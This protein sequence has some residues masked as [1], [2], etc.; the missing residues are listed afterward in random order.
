MHVFALQGIYI[1]GLPL[2]CLWRSTFH[3]VRKR[4]PFMSKVAIEIRQASADLTSGAQVVSDHIIPVTV[5]IST[6]HA[7]SAHCRL[8]L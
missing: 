4:S 3:A 5:G 7:I 1:A 2:R 6:L 8:D